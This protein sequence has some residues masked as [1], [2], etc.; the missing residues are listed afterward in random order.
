MK[1]A[2]MLRKYSEKG[3]LDGDAIKR[4]L[5]GAMAHKPVRTP[6]VKVS[7]AVYAKYFK[8]NQPT[9]E[10]QAIVEKAL[11]LYFEQEKKQPE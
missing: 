10:V 5:S 2:D 1:K 4:I 3:R 11:A 7:K 6:T 9:S 8:P